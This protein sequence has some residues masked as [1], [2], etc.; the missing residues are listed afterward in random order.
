MLQAHILYFLARINYI[1]SFWLCQDLGSTYYCHC[2][3]RE[4]QCKLIRKDKRREFSFKFSQLAF[5]RF[6]ASDKIRL[7]SFSTRHND[8][9]SSPGNWSSS[10]STLWSSCIGELDRL[11][12]PITNYSN[13]LSIRPSSHNQC[14]VYNYTR[15]AP[16]SSLRSFGPP[17]G[18]SGL[19]LPL[20]VVVLVVVVV[21][22]PV[23]VVLVLLLL[24]LV[25]V[26]FKTF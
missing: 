11:I 14:T 3:E 15:S 7:H 9:Q 25:V 24:L 21:L 19:L 26:K 1:I 5:A 17:L 8:H 23:V 16:T 22:L 18:P 12:E 13:W 4:S 6:F 10:S 20:N 2:S